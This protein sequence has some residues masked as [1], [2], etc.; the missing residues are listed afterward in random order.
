MQKRYQFC[1]LLVT[2]CQEI[3]MSSFLFV[4]LNFDT[5]PKGQ[6]RKG[7]DNLLSEE[8]VQKMEMFGMEET[9]EK[10]SYIIF[11]VP[12]KVDKISR[13]QI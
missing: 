13:K 3:L 8:W 5:I 1:C 11:M 10:L 2:S 12:E 6:Y 4:K 7:L 9:Y